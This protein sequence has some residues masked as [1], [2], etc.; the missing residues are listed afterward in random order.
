MKNAGVNPSQID[1]FYAHGTGSSANDLAE[2]KAIQSLFNSS[3]MDSKTAAVS[4][5]KS[6]HGHTLG[7]CGALESVLSIMSLQK[8]LIL[9]TFNTKEIDPAI[10]LDVVLKPREKKLNMIL[11]NS[12]GFGGI[13]ASVI[14]TK[15]RGLN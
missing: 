13:N 8:N 5:T 15:T 6:I 4:S 7:A 3:G 2:S 9:P 1:W 12:L 11:K 10:Q 14:L